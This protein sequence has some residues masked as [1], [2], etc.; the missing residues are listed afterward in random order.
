ACLNCKSACFDIDSE[1]NYW[2][3]LNKPGRKLVQYGYLGLV[4]GYF[5][6]YYL[7][8]GNFW[9]YFSGAWTHEEGL[10]NTLFKPDFYLFGQP[11]PIPKLV[12]SPLTLALCVVITC[13]ICSQI[14]KALTTY[15]RRHNPNTN[16]QQAIHKMFS[17]CTFIAFNFF[18]IYGGRP[19]I[20]RLPFA[21][22]FTFNAGVVLVSSLWLYRTWGR[23]FEDY[24]RESIAYKL[25]RQL[26]KL[27]LDF[28]NILQGRSLDDLN[29]DQLEILTQVLPS[30]T[31]QERL[32]VYQGVLM[33]A[34]SEKRFSPDK[35]RDALKSL[36][37]K[38]NISN[39][40]HDQVLSSVI[41]E[42]GQLAQND[43]G[44]ALAKTTIRPSK[45]RKSA[46]SNQITQ[47]R[48]KKNSN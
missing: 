31:Q 12:A 42:I 1:K 38:L 40:E 18:F 34:L 22:Q 28:S 46:L 33:E 4:I 7:Y 39:D 13:F 24:N 29:P 45:T 19:E 48:S 6:Y 27:S 32:S 43:V 9:Y 16:R 15:L 2:E 23:S 47:I 35:S 8:S 14:E 44:L 3:E 5:I 21:V 20:L 17:L 10:I 30:V 26:K 41:P 25:R 37:D 36:R 11:I